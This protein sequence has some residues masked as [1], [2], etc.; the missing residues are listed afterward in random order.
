MCI[1][2]WS[3]GRFDLGVG[4]GYAANEFRSL[5]IPRKERSAR[6]AEG[7]ELVRR[8]WTED[9]V[10]FDGRFTQVKDMTLSPK[11]VQQPHIPVWI[12]ARADKA[13]QRVARMGCHLM[14]YA[15][16]RPGTALYPNPER[17][18]LRPCQL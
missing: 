2:I 12:G 6:L 16:T 8:L 1:D 5:G 15:R 14:A 17:T 18:R 10:T 13:I 3:N 9:N 4:Q 7:V 11:P